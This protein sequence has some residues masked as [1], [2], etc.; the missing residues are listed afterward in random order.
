MSNRFS[1]RNISVAKIDC[2][3]I[4]LSLLVAKHSMLIASVRRH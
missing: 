3:T 2:F 4:A 1:G